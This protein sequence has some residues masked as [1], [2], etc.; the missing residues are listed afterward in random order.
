MKDFFDSLSDETKEIQDLLYE[1]FSEVNNELENNL[2]I[3]DDQFEEALKRSIF[4]Y[5]A[6]YIAYIYQN[7]EK[8]IS[9]QLHCNNI[10]KKLLFHGTS[11][12]CISRILG[13]EFR[14]SN[15]HIFGPGIYFSDS[16]DYTWYY[17]DDS[18]SYERKNFEIIPEIG[19]SFSFIAVNVYYDK[20]KFEQIYEYNELKENEKVQDFGIRHILVDSK[21]GAIPKNILKNYNN[22]FKGTEYLISNKSQILPLLSVTMERVKYLIVWRDNN[23]IFI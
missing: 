19:D 1:K 13:S 6:K 21:S 14:N 22:K 7:D 17:S 23:F 11:S 18:D 12:F 2:Q 5:Q 8:F 16:L 10:E 3:F 20:N 9:G 15:V 4:E